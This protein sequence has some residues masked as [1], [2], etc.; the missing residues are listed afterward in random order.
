MKRIQ[1]ATAWLRLRRDDGQDL[2]EYAL[3]TLLVSVVAIAAIKAVGS[4]VLNSF[5]SVISA[6]IP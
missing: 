3:L 5:W 4:V 2:I 1:T 6:A